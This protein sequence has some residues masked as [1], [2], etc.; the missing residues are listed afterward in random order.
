M[1][2]ILSEDFCYDYFW[3][4]SKLILRI[5]YEQITESNLM[6]NI[7]TLIKAL[8]RSHKRYEV[9][10]IKSTL[11]SSQDHSIFFSMEF[12][13]AYLKSKSER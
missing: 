7:L 6:C 8:R 11:Y 9:M 1:S 3:V 10:F 12:F 5:L 13:F 4:S 2:R